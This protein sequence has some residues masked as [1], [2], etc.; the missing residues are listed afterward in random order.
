MLRS[1]YFSA[2]AISLMMGSVA[3]AATWP[4]LPAACTPDRAV[5]WDDSKSVNH[6][7]ACHC[8][9]PNRCPATLQ[10]AQ[11]SKSLIPY[12]L[13]LR[14]CDLTDE[15]CPAGEARSQQTGA[16]VAVCPQGSALAGQPRPANGNC[17]PCRD[18]QHG[19]G[20]LSGPSGGNLGDTPQCPKR[21]C[22]D[23]YGGGSMG[24][25]NSS[26]NPNLASPALVNAMRAYPNGVR[27]GVAQGYDAGEFI[28]P[29][30][31][32]KIIYYEWQNIDA[33]A[34]IENAA[35][36][37]LQRCRGPREDAQIRVDGTGRIVLPNNGYGYGGRL[38][39]YEATINGNQCHYMGCEFVPSERSQ[40]T[41]LT[42]ET[43][44]TLA[45]GS[46]RKVA[47]IKVG[48]VVKSSTG[49]NVVAATNVYHAKDRLFY[50]INGKG[51]MITGYHPIRT[52]HGWKVID[53]T[54][55]AK[56][57]QTP[58]YSSAQLQV[59]DVIVTDKGEVTV[60]EIVG[61]DSPAVVP[62][63]NLHFEKGGSFYA[64]GIEVKG[65]DKMEMHYE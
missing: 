2:I 63:Y 12:E 4:S 16:C 58:G 27:V 49:T 48:D 37:Y 6:Q 56:I 15:P 47:D 26:S 60:K 52:T 34:V 19:D 43:N 35:S 25:L 20:G 24:L 17:N 3:Q 9:P 11:S 51:P 65:F 59:G 54:G 18:P 53:S 23:Q 40:T 44:V 36:A 31:K 7:S 46:S 61:V 5:K 45:D 42:G 21:G 13:A 55:A 28:Q 64:N 41:C 32:P 57:G 33:P 38:T 1:V 10:Q 50:S 62:S 30:Q 8:P 39:V 29:G 14:C 22:P